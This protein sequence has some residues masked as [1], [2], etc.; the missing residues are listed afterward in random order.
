MNKDQ[1][2]LADL[3]IDETGAVLINLNYTGTSAMK[4]V[5]NL[6]KL[7]TDENGVLLVKTDTTAFTEI[8]RPQRWEDLLVDD[9][10][11][12]VVKDISNY[13]PPS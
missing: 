2:A 9:N 10:G 8:K 13:T 1:F 6:N 7:A 3:L 5:D 4:H 11:A 12:L